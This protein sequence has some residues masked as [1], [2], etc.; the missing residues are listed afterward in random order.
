[1]Q[2]GLIIIC[3]VDDLYRLMQNEQSG[4]YI[5]MHSGNGRWA[6]LQWPTKISI[7]DACRQCHL[8]LTATETS[9]SPIQIHCTY[10]SLALRCMPRSPDFGDFCVHDNN[11]DDNGRTN[12]FT[13]LHMHAGYDKDVI[14][15]VNW[16]RCTRLCYL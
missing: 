9:F 15:Y 8:I 6:W 1:M 3:V 4:A 7:Y 10:N 16:S 14:E 11:D 13:P 5:A 12:C 2:L